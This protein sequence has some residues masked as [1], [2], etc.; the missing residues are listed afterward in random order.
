MPDVGFLPSWPFPSSPLALFGVLLLCGVLGGELVKR[1]FK[2]PRIIGYVLVGMLL[3]S[4][5]LGLLDRERTQEA[6][7]FVEIALGLVLF[8]LGRRLDVGW[9]RKERWLLATGVLESALAFGCIFGALVYFE[10]K[11][12]FAAVAAAIG[13]ST[14]PAVVML[15]ARDLRA[16]GQVTERAL[17]LVAINSVIAF[18]LLTMLLSLIHHEYAADWLT[19]ALHPVYMLSGSVLLAYVAYGAALLISR[20]LGKNAE[21]QFV[22]LLALVILAVGLSRMF[23]LSVLLSLL[24]FGV[25]VRNLDRGYH[26]MPVE[27]GRVGQLFFVV[28]FVVTGAQ[29]VP[30]DLMAGGLLGLVFILAR[31]VGKSVAVMALTRFTGVRAGSAGLLCIALMPM[32]AIALAMVESTTRVYPEFGGQLF[33]IIMSAVL[34]LELVGPLAVQFALRRAGEAAEEEA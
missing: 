2:L 29:L 10:V 23:E 32:S 15:V 8:E 21:R 26:M 1:F 9:L 27:M 34:I 3:G 28:L 4:G 18:T 7:I 5:G 22:V 16:E 20:W 6:W 12:L 11:P 33:S 14:S 17:H 30:G 13:V 24:L 25:M 31:F 19:V